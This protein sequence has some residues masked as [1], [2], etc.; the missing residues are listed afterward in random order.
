MNSR[1]KQPPNSALA[2]R[3]P[4][5]LHDR[6]RKEAAARSMSLAQLVIVLLQHGLDDL[7]PAQPLDLFRK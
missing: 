4:S 3:I 2:C 7:G 5:E 1:P 6:L